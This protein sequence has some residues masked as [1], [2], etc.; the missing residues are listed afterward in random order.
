MVFV[1]AG[2]AARDWTRH[3]RRAALARA[4][5][6]TWG[7][8]RAGA[9]EQ[10]AAQFLA[11][12]EQRLRRGRPIRG[13][14]PVRHIWVVRPQDPFCSRAARAMIE[15]L[16]LVARRP[17]GRWGRAGPRLM[18]GPDSRQ[19]LRRDQ[20]DLARLRAERPEMHPA[21]PSLGEPAGRSRGRR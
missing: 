8:Q 20:V 2:Y 21:A 7:N 16:Q 13:P 1:L 6:R 12:A 3:E 10:L 4:A 5:G 15:T 9:Q 18:S 14:A 19:H 17:A 11:P